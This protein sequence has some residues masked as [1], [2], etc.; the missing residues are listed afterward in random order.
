MGRKKSFF[1][2]PRKPSL[3]RALGISSAKSKF[4]KMTG[5]RAARN[6]KAFFQNAEKR[7]KRRMGIV[8]PSEWWRRV[9]RKSRPKKD[10]PQGCWPFR[11]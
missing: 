2:K 3:N 10:E 1:P 5:G 6:P 7:A 4:T 8:S 11:F 9:G